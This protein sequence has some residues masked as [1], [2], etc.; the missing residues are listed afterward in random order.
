MKSLRI[1]AYDVVVEQ[2]KHLEE[3]D[4]YGDFKEDYGNYRIRIPP[5]KTNKIAIADTLI[6]ETLHAIIRIYNI[7]TEDTD[8]EKLVTCLGTALTQV[9]RD[10]PELLPYLIELTE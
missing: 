8:E 10:T 9:I 2:C 4:R 6:H 3:L 5:A 7:E 1:S